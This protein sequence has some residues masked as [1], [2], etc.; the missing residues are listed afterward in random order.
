[1]FSE[2]DFEQSHF[3]GRHLTLARF[4]ATNLGYATFRR[5]TL[6]SV[7]L[8]DADLFETDF[9]HATLREINFR[10]ACLRR[11]HLERAVI[12]GALWIDG[13]GRERA[14]PTGRLATPAEVANMVRSSID[15]P[16]CEKVVHFYPF[17][18]DIGGGKTKPWPLPDDE[19]DAWLTK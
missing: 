18:L 15:P 2:G 3:D 11:V 8:S 19:A 12:N 13:L 17:P 16:R 7:S 5:T 6:E 9:T 1:L 4:E 10:G 14:L